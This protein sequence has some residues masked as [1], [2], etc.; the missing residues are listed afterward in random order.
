[1]F[2]FDNI[3]KSFVQSFNNV[4][5]KISLNIKM[6]LILLN[7]VYI[8]GEWVM[9]DDR[10]KKPLVSLQDLSEINSSIEDQFQAIK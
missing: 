2:F 8:V 10:S 6:I 3:L 7:N 5:L 4:N 1:M 9:Q